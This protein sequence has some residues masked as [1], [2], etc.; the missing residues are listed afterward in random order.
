MRIA[1]IGVMAAAIFLSSATAQEAPPDPVEL[2]RPL[3][4]RWEGGFVDPPVEGPVHVVEFEAMLGGTAVRRVKWVSS[5]DPLQESLYF[6]DPRGATVRFLTLS[7]LGYVSRGRVSR[8]GDRIV[9]E[10]TQVG[11]DSSDLVR[12]TFEITPDGTLQDRFFGLVDG[13]WTQRHLIEYRPVGRE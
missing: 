8:E 9:V 6:K 1:V 7:S 5:D 3:L 11:P 4:G 13:V 10:G 12:V 2:F